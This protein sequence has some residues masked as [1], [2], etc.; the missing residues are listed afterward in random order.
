MIRNYANWL[1]R[2][3][4]LVILLTVGV[5]LAAG[6]GVRFLKFDTDYRIFFG[7]DNPQL[8]AF[9]ELQ[10]SYT[11]DDN[12]M[13]V[14]T[15]KSGQVFDAQSMSVIKDLTKQAWQIPY[16]IRVDSLTNYQHTWV[17]ED[18][19]V[20][21]DLVDDPTAITAQGWQAIQNIA[22][23]EPLL[24]HR[25]VNPQSTVTAVNVTIQLPDDNTQT[26]V[27]EI[28]AFVRNMAA[29]LQA[30]HPE[31]EV[32]LTG[33]VM[34][35]NSF[36]ELS[37]R[38]MSTL[39]PMMFG[40]VILTF[41]MLL[42]SP[43]AT[44]GTLLVILF[45]IIT[46][47][48]L[49]G[50]SGIVLTGPSASAPTIILTMAVADA[51]HLLVSFFVVYGYKHVDK[52]GA[53]VEALR[54]N[55]APIFLT[56]LTTAIGFLSMNFSDAPP[57]RD[58]GNIV[59]MGVVAA[60][61]Y[62]V[63]FLPV[64]MA[65]VP[66]KPHKKRP[67]TSHAMEMLANWVIA[68]R[69]P[70]FYI[71]TAVSIGFIAF[72]P[73][74][75]LNDEFVKYFSKNVDFRNATD[76]TAANLT[77]IYNIG[78]SIDS[79]ENSGIAD[80]DFL[81]RVEQLA[82]W[83]RTQPE[84][85]HVSTITD[86]FKRLNRN[87][88]GDQPQ[89]YAL[90]D[91]RNLAA[92]YLLLY[93]MSLPYGLD[94]NNQINVN[95]SKTRLSVTLQSISSNEVLAFAD[96]V[97]GW[98]QKNWPAQMV[99]E[100]ASPTVMFAHIGKRNIVSMLGGTTVALFLI[101][102]SMIIALR[103]VKLGLL[104]LIPNL[105]PA[106]IA[107]G[108]WGM[109]NGQVG[110]ALSVVTGMTLGIIVDDTVHFLSKYLRARREYHHTAEEAVRYAFSTVGTALWVTTLVLVAGFLVLTLSD[111]KLNAEMGLMTAIAIA[112]AL[113]VDFLLLPVLLLKMEGKN[114]A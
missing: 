12:V 42:H 8:L 98:M 109:I 20:V 104:S 26:A 72:I 36:P 105:V 82:I 22:T 24:L 84:V 30:A 37:K 46:G 87:M 107:F 74:N 108:L 17:E 54:I 110:L 52:H 66:V 80:P 77:G 96:R 19:L 92:Q 27:P 59:S 64:F 39:V 101:S 51:V 76:Y 50:W 25:L 93:E 99:V 67:R 33:M 7:K 11:K 43:W 10:N 57:F 69:T 68:K 40:V 44:L 1:L 5:M 14:L 78:F 3:R 18:D 32:R 83:L 56:S 23:T 97:R 6:S 103:S 95:K 75:Q 49:A 62:A 13:F 47:M 15:P 88:H 114:H 21:G 112:I 63:T 113:I 106:G 4:L 89:W 41:L 45:S 9:D 31:M 16:S 61:V 2:Y 58:L 71:M 55:F 65:M 94:L 111:F 79:G 100:G 60:F 86:I 73:R 85:T 91:E 29:Q 38:D 81:A 90:P 48:G 35:N 28:A 102:L 70:L 53:M 34:M